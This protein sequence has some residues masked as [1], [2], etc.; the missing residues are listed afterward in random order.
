M[1]ASLVVLSV[2]TALGVLQAPSAALAQRDPTGRWDSREF[3]R[4][5]REQRLRACG[6]YQD[7]REK[8][9]ASPKA[10]PRPAMASERPAC[11]R[12]KR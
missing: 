1:K 3:P 8:S 9:V 11:G 4:E 5:Q 6:D 12:R 7:L 10:A 2:V